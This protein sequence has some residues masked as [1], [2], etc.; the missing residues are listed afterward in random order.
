MPKPS[1]SPILAAHLLL[2]AI[3]LIWGATFALIKSALVDISPLLFN[4]LR[5]A[6]AFLLLA[7]INLRT[8][9]QLTRRDLYFGAIA[10]LFLS[11]GYQFQTS[12]L[13][14]TTASKSAFITGLIVVIVPLL[15][16]LPGVRRPG[17]PHPGPSDFTGAILAFL[18]LIL[19]TTP[20]HSGA[21]IFSGFGIGET[22]TL[23][24]AIAFAVHLLTLNRAAPYTGAR[25]LGTLQIGFCTLVLLI[26]LPLGGHPHFHLTTRVVLALAVTAIL[27]TA[28]AF[29]IQ[30]WAQQYLPAT[31]TALIFTL[32]PIFAW[33]TSLFFLNEHLGKR[34]LCGASLI[35]LG[36]LAAELGPTLLQK[37][38]ILLEASQAS[39]G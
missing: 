30:S 16:A 15:S 20:P 27:G 22:L 13:A 35:L 11:L 37:P 29:T 9:R 4:L 17:T 26:T 8:L 10:G 5:M 1:H 3:T 2:I 31:N 28:A 38:R 14:R 39:E 19:L 32:E 34:A 33:L 25:L 21:A 18:G 12:G 23:A 36:I 6:L 24:C 7:A